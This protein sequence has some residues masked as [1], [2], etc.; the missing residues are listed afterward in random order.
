MSLEQ[1]I[2]NAENVLFRTSD[3][4]RI[5]EYKTNIIRYSDLESVNNIDDI[6]H[7]DACVI[8]YQK[9]SNSGHWISI[10]KAPWD[11]NL[12]Y[13]FD[14]YGYDID[15]EI[16][17][18]DFQLSR[19]NNKVVPHLTRL[20]QMSK[21]KIQSNNIQYQLFDK[22]INTC[23]RWASHRLLHRNLNPKQYYNYMY[24]NTQYNPDFWVS[25]ATLQNL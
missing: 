15:E 16:Q 22:H 8:L 17:Y 25:L 12:L 23:G 14:P 18:S 20:I 11:N 21:Y 2:L 9:K 5:T 7:Y 24:K 13:F 1:R 10:F 3:I 6:L 4:E 19:H